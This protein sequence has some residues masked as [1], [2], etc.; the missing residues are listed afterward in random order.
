MGQPPSN[1]E[2]FK[3]TYAA[4][5]RKFRGKELI[6]C[7]KGR[8]INP[9]PNIKLIRFQEWLKEDQAYDAMKAQAAYDPDAAKLLKRTHRMSAQKWWDK[10]MK[11]Q[12]P[13][14]KTSEPR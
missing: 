9:K 8:F 3:K 6:P 11:P 7:C 10:N 13:K 1:L 12:S 4:A 5:A 2:L 14:K